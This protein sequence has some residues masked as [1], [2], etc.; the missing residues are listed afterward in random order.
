MRL[1]LICL[2]TSAAC[3][4]VATELQFPVECKPGTGCEI[5]NYV[6]VD[7]SEISRDY[8]C[9]TRTYNGH[10][11]TD[12]RIPSMQVQ[13]LGVH[14]LAAA[15][16][17][18][19][20]ARDGVPD[21]SVRTRGAGAV[22]GQECGNALVI[23][24]GGGLETQYCHM[25][26]S[27]L[28]VRPGQ[29][30][31]AGEPIGRIGL[32]GLTEYPH[33][34][35]IVRERGRIVDPFARD[36]PPGACGRESSMWRAADRDMLGYKARAVLNM[37]FSTGPVTM[38]SIESGLAEKSVRADSALTVFVR[39]IGGKRGDVQ[40]LTIRAP[41]GSILVEKTFP[42][43]DNHKAQAFSAVGRKAPLS[44]WPSGIYEASYSVVNGKAVVFERSLRTA[45]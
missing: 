23:D 32:S 36:A 28:R 11:G 10:N 34:H 22:E 35:F 24:H 38:D 42:P 27:S 21:L 7:P 18:V 39:L 33:L 29:D 20:R 3:T 30:V 12:I 31:T 26:E 9:G 17:R 4:S 41:N 8:T 6:D 45:I 44:G 40:R 37:G 1:I 16:G 2:L 25:A 19:V 14:V 43:L 13:Q 15:S 5:Q